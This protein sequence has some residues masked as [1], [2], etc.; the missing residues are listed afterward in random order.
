[1]RQ[2]VCPF[3]LAA[4][5]HFSDIQRGFV[6]QRSIATCNA[7]PPP[8]PLVSSR[9]PPRSVIQSS[10]WGHDS[11][12][13]ACDLVNATVARTR[14]CRTE[15]SAPR[16]RVRARRPLAHDR[17]HEVGFTVPDLVSPPPC[18]PGYLSRCTA[19]NAAAWPRSAWPRVVSAAH[20]TVHPFIFDGLHPSYSLL[21]PSSPSVTNNS[22]NHKPASRTLQATCASGI[23]CLNTCCCLRL[24]LS[25]D[26]CL[27]GSI[28]A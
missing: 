8:P 5:D 24:L 28:L 4:Y 13:V 6:D 7:F 2:R 25:C 21:R 15:R 18:K 1:M 20:L 11:A 3:V 14:R 26:S 19:C 10:G 9:I 27:P 23:D 17:C 16:E 22:H 12:H